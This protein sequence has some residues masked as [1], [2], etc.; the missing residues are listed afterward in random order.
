[1][2]SPFPGMDPYIED[3]EVW[4]DFHSDLAGEIR[5]QLNPHIQ[6]AYVARLVPRVTYD[7]VEV[8]RTR[9]VRP[10]VAVWK[11]LRETAGTPI[12]SIPPAPAE[13]SIT[14]ELPLRLHTVEIYMTRSPTQPGWPN[15]S[16]TSECSP[17]FLLPAHPHTRSP[18]HLIT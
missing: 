4:S 12:T 14:L 8:A 16:P 10:D 17:P 15:I 11:T 1:M 3:P 2:P 5:A 13:S 7:I 9:G 6:P 18:H